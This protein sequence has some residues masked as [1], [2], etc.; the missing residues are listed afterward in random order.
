[1]NCS[2]K[3]KGVFF[4]K[5]YKKA[6]NNFYKF[7]SDFTH[8]LCGRCQEDGVHSN[9]KMLKFLENNGSDSEVD[10]WLND[11]EHGFVHG[12]SV[13]FVAW[14]LNNKVSS[15]TL[16]SCLLHDFLR[17]N[18]ID[19]NHDIL[20]RN[21]FSHLSEETYRHSNP[22][23][24]DTNRLLIIADREE[25]K[26]YDDYRKWID[27]S[28]FTHSL[29]EEQSNILN[30]YY[31]HIRPGICDVFSHYDEIWLRHGPE[32]EMKSLRFSEI[33]DYPDSSGNVGG[34]NYSVELD[35]MPLNG[36]CGHGRSK[37]Y[38]QYVLKRLHDQKQP[39]GIQQFRC[40]N[41]AL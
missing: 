15:K 23:D 40:L 22:L 11:L 32:G 24:T 41:L 30:I 33:K 18:G 19:D 25:L 7:L 21:I 6:E 37:K 35:K 9:E 26:R 13:C 29:T 34:N 31:Q 4:P 2:A 39:K 17:S 20:L 8:Y 38:L 5:L 1:M 12:L 16:A 27:T 10:N 3:D 28:L 36:C 14:L